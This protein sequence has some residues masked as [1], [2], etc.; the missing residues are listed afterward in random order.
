MMMRVAAVLLATCALT[1]GAAAFTASP[2][3]GGVDAFT[4]VQLRCD[5]NGCIDL[6]TG[7]I[8]M[9]GCDYRGCYPTSGPV[10]RRYGGGSPH[11]RH[12]APPAYQPHYRRRPTYGGGLRCDHNGCTD[13][14]TGAITMS[15]CNYRGCYPTSGPVARRYGGGVIPYGPPQGYYGW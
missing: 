5:H 4:R 6:S 10:A 2:A 15:S 7:A 3:G 11:W 13:L 12:E 14:R 9:S 1:S 8:T